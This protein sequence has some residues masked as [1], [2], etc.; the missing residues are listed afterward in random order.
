M[1][2]SWVQSCLLC[3]Q[4]QKPIY[5]WSD[6]ISYEENTVATGNAEANKDA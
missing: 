6:W 2:F 3:N 5:S 1:I 4:L